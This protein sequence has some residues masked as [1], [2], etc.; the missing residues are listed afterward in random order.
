MG[1]NIYQTN[2]HAGEVAPSGASREDVGFYLNGAKRLRDWRQLG[3]GGITRRPGTLFIDEIAA[4]DIVA[5]VYGYYFSHNQK[6]ILVFKSTKLVIFQSDVQIQE[7]TGLPWTD[8]EIPTLSIAAAG[9]TIIVA[10]HDMKPQRILRTGATTFTVGDYTYQTH[11]SGFPIYQPYHK[12]EAAAVTLAASATTGS[13]TI[14][15]STGIFS[16]SWNGKIIRIGGK[17]VT[18]GTYAGPSTEM[19][20]TV[21][22][23]LA[24]TTATAD[25]DE[26]AF[27][28]HRGWPTSAE[29]HSSRFYFGGAKSL[30]SYIFGTKIEA[31]FNFDVGTAQDNEAI[32]KQITAGP[33]IR[34][35]VSGRNLQIFTAEAEYYVP[36]SVANPITPSGFQFSMQTPYGSS[37]VRPRSL[38]GA[39]LF[40]QRNGAAIY[41]FLY[42]DTQQAYASTNVSVL[43]TH[44]IDAPVDMAVQHAYVSGGTRGAEQYAYVLNEDGTLAVFNSNRSEKVAGWSLWTTAGEIKSIC[45]LDE[46]IYLVV[47]REINGVTKTFL[48]KL[49]DDTKLDC[50]LS[51]T[52]SPADT[53]FAGFDH[54]AEDNVSVVAGRS[55]LGDFDVDVSGNI[56]LE[57]AEETI[58]AGFNFTPELETLPPSRQISSGSIAGRKKRIARVL[59]NV[60]DSVTWSVN[61]VAMSLYS[62]TDDL[63]AE[64][65]LK[66]GFHE[67]FLRGWSREPTVTITQPHP[68]DLTIIGLLTEVVM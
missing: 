45:E 66:S 6:Y 25:W 55:Y 31:Y 37:W 17:T 11:S 24:G 48:E 49:S 14:T 3:L 18:L 61:G 5:N 56:T 15:A 50:A 38:D 40:V 53:V 58:Y 23:T 62:V 35:L 67:I 52:N 29:F 1:Q 36:Q 4:T 57:A 28:T 32:I 43:S 8:A 41:E 42:S 13:I 59:L 9:D 27:N 51:V 21:N 10:H 64:P 63:S 19:P 39:T 34:H 60:L 30:P 22:E 54:L 20:G 68:S 65:Q 12:Y 7:I 44:L 26:S 33:E 16:A 46:E 2:L 47:H